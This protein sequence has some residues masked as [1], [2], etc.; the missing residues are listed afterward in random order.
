MYTK[1]L[2]IIFIFFSA[3]NL[4]SQT[5]EF[6]KVMY[7]NSKEGLRLRLEPSLDSSRIGVV[8]HG[9][10]IRVYEKSSIPISIDGITGYWFRT[11]GKYYE[12]K[13]YTWAWVFGGYLTEQL[14]E[15]VPAILGYW[16]VVDKSRNY[17]SFRPDHTFSEG[18][19]E[20]DRG[21]R[22]TWSINNNLLTIII[23]GPIMDSYF[24]EIIEYKPETIIINLTIHNRDD[25]ILNY[26][27][28]E[29]IK[30]RRN[31]GLI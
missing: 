19:K 30:L 25:I 28:G 2:I 16:D 7:V 27:N 5:T 22:G 21:F 24:D 6:P 31:N 26:P 20:T 29:I 17:Y 23:T 1:K 18:Y 9:E 12:G 3:L 15:D 4:F 13:W 8:L 10:R 11:D 14:P